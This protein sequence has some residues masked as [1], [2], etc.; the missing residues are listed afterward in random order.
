VAKLPNWNAPGSDC[1]NVFVLKAA[2]PVVCQRLVQLF[3]ISVV[4]GQFPG[5]FKKAVIVP[6]PKKPNASTA[7]CI[8]FSSRQSYGTSGVQSIV[9]LHE[10]SFHRPSI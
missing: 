3:N 5:P 1:I 2:L 4:V 10:A 9:C 6:V 7:D 8:N